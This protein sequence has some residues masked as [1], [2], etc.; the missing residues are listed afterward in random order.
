MKV[1]RGCQIL[2]GANAFVV[3]NVGWQQLLEAVV[4]E[5]TTCA[6]GGGGG[7]DNF[8]VQMFRKQLLAHR[9]CHAVSPRSVESAC[10]QVRATGGIAGGPKIT[11]IA[12]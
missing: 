4:S 1:G 12:C 2:C 11:S 5:L 10:V 7:G 3:T 8:V 9:R 6:I